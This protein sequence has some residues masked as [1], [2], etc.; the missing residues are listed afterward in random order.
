[1]PLTPHTKQFG[2][3][4]YPN[5]IPG[6]ADVLEANTTFSVPV[7]PVACNAYF[8]QLIRGRPL[9]TEKN[10]NILFVFIIHYSYFVCL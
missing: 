9:N 7:Q 2:H 4:S 10:E 5:T 6:H 1:M 8:K 3:S